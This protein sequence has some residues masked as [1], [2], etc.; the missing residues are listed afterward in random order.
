[1]WIN[2]FILT[3]G[4]HVFHH[5]HH[6]HTWFGKE[7]KRYQMSPARLLIGGSHTHTHFQPPSADH[8]W[9]AVLQECF[10]SPHS[11]QFIVSIIRSWRVFSPSGRGA[12]ERSLEV[13]KRRQIPGIHLLS[14]WLSA[15]AAA[16]GVSLQY[17][18][19]RQEIL[20][21]AAASLKVKRE[22]EKKNH[23]QSWVMAALFHSSLVSC[24][25][26]LAIIN[27]DLFLITAPCIRTD[28]LHTCSC[29]HLWCLGPAAWY[30][31]TRY[32]LY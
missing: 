25:C 10:S 2:L 16:A 21:T 17:F 28:S 3:T 26:A 7:C 12:E 19:H 32:T 20:Q 22:K 29:D 18:S 11:W 24:P 30:L 15:A 27:S 5:T 1:M 9:L 23:L 31:I 6:D 14:V 13:E 4:L 8:F